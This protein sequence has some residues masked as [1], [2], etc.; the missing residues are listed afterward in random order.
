[1]RAILKSTS[2]TYF[3]VSILFIS[4]VIF[5]TTG[6]LT[7]SKSNQQQIE[8]NVSQVNDL[9]TYQ[10]P[11]KHSGYYLYAKEFVVN[12]QRF[13]VPFTK[14]SNG[15]EIS[16]IQKNQYITVHYNND[17]NVYRVSILAK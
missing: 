11:G 7:V 6:F 13:V 17:H 3:I 1:M 15:S 16:H 5:V 9:Y 8:G 10:S 4:L 2:L 14:I 12:E